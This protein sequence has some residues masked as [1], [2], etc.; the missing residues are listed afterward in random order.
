MTVTLKL[1]DLDGTK[2]VAVEHLQTGYQ[3]HL[4]TYPPHVDTTV[5]QGTRRKLYGHLYIR[6]RKLQVRFIRVL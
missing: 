6:K 3:L 1:D 4:G 2:K 5:C